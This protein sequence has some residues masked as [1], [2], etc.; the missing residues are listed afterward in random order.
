MGDAPKE[1]VTMRFDRNV[2]RAYR[3]TGKGWQARINADLQMALKR[4][5]A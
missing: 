3:A 4:K 1:A 2:L 5:R